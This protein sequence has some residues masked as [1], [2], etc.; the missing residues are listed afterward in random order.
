[1]SAVFGDEPG[2][3]NFV[4]QL[5]DASRAGGR[6]AVADDQWV[7]P[8]CAA[9]LGAVV[10]DVAAAGVAGVLDAAGAEVVRRDLFARAVVDMLGLRSD[11]VDAKGTAELALLAP[12]PLRVGLDTA[13]LRRVTRRVIRSPREALRLIRET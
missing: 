2:R 13:L 9:D 10:V 5:V 12:R 6:V 1:V 3:K 4:L 8:T 11:V 7:T